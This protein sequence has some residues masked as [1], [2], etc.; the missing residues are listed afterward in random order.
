MFWFAMILTIVS[1]VFYHI[2]QK[3]TPQEANPALALAVVGYYAGLVLAIGGA[4]LL[5][6]LQVVRLPLLQR[7]LEPPVVV[8]VDVIWDLL[9]EL[10]QVLLKSKLGRSGLP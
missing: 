4:G 2:F 3:V 1:N 5:P 6:P 8:Q 10:H 9:V 7:A